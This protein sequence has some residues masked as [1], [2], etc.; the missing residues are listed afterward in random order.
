MYEV[1]RDAE[2]KELNRVEK[3]NMITKAPVTEVIA[4]GTKVEVPEEPKVT[5]SEEMKTEP[6]GYETQYVDDPELLEGT[7]SVQTAGQA[8]E[9]TIVYEVTRD[10][11]GKELNR[12]E[13]SNTITKAPVTEVVVRG[14]KP[15][16]TV[17]EEVVLVEIPYTSEIQND[18]ELLKGTTSVRTAGQAG[19][20]TIV[21]EVTRDAEGK[22]LARVEKSSKITKAPVNEVVAQGTKLYAKPLVELTSADEAVDNKTSYR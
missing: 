16:T 6:V 19:E 17:T 2:G 9:R 12:V 18:P 20:R 21:Y 5:V 22:E 11:E 8:G 7:T 13:K 15:K 3:S 4:R 14:T 10:A 1:T